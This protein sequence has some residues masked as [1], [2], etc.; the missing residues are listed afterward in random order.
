VLKIFSNHFG[1]MLHLLHASI[2]NIHKSGYSLHGSMPMRVRT[3]VLTRRI[4]LS[5]ILYRHDSCVT[6]AYL[7]NDNL[8]TL[9]I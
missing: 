4:F 1:S 7:I 6:V 2:S 5:T 9:E 8:V 3:I